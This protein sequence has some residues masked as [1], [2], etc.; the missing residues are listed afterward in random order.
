MKK[1]FEKSKELFKNL[2]GR[3]DHARVRQSRKDIETL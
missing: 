1:S 3:E 2:L